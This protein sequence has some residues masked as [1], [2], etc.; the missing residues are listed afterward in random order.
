MPTIGRITG[1]PIA[2]NGTIIPAGTDIY[3]SW[4]TMHRQKGIWG[5]DASEFNPDRFLPER[6]NERH[7]FAWTPFSLG[8]RN[9]IGYIYAKMSFKISVIQFIRAYKVKTS[10][11]WKDIEW[12]H[13]LHLH[14][15]KPHL[16][17]VEKRE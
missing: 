6:T 10:L 17:S 4:F 11:K 5:E 14:I 16:I 9:C 8:V 1:V 2:Y 3:V 13:D 15:T 7:H 12:K